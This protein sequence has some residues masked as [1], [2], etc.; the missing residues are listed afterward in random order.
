MKHL[1]SEPETAFRELLRFL[2]LPFEDAVLTSARSK[3]DP[4]TSHSAKVVQNSRKAEDYFDC[5]TVKHIESVAG[6]LLTEL[7][8]ACSDQTGDLDPP[9]WQLEWWRMTDDVRRFVM[10]ALKRGRIL[11]PSKW[12]YIAATDSKRPQAAG[13]VEMVRQPN[14]CRRSR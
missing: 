12:R 4:A 11:R 2:D 8:Y 5:A 10:V 3:A 13:D 7:G 9:N 6:R 14:G 1:P